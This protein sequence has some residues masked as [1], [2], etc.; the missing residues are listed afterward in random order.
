MPPVDTIQAAVRRLPDWC[1]FALVVL[2]CFGLFIAVSLW[3]YFAPAGGASGGRSANEFGSIAE[4]TNVYVE[5]LALFAT[6]LFLSVRGWQLE[7]FG[8]RISWGSSAAGVGL[9]AAYLACF[10]VGDWLVWTVPAADGDFGFDGDIDIL[11]LGL[12]AFAIVLNSV[13]EEGIVV[14]Y[15][16]HFVGSRHGTVWAIIASAGI[17]LVYHLYQGNYAFL[18][19]GPMG[20]LFSLFYWRY[21]NLWPLIVAHTLLNAPFV[22]L[23]FD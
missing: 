17:R 6:V 4:L 5:A 21:R 9:V 20:I 15:V 8:F 1:E 19:I 23:W 14:G 3:M 22:L 18:S 12:S 7:T 11:L 16:M 10:Y 2:M 13:Y